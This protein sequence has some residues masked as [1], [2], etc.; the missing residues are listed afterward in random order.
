MELRD[1][2]SRRLCHK[3]PSVERYDE[4]RVRL[5]S[6]GKRREDRDARLGDIGAK[7]E[8]EGVKDDFKIL[9]WDELEHDKTI[10]EKVGRRGW[11]RTMGVQIYPCIYGYSL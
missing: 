10:C 9:I 5:W 7:G 3:G 1:A 8:E 2:G 11:F 4:D 6:G